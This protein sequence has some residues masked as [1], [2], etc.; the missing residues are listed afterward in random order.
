MGS[1]LRHDT[2]RG[3]HEKLLPDFGSL[4]PTVSDRE[5]LPDFGSL[6]PTVPDDNKMR[7][8]NKVVQLVEQIPESR[9]KLTSKNKIEMKLQSA[10]MKELL[11]LQDTLAA[12]D[13]LQLRRVGLTR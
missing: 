11:D 6:W 5:L 12:G 2:G 9:R 4:W 8:N 10:R 3:L 1:L 13:H 7:L